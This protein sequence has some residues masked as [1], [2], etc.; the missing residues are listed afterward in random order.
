MK[1]YYSFK[2]ML[3]LFVCVVIVASFSSCGSPQTLY[4]WHKYENAAYK[5]SKLQTEKTNK[6]FDKQIKKVIAK[7]KGRRKTV[8]PGILA[9]YGFYL[10]KAGKPEE[11]STYFKKEIATYP[12]SEIFI[13]RIIKQI[14]Q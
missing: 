11:A 8:P 13:S 10:Y 6:E 5:N 12:E 14:E 7:Q 4:S 9:E 3:S 2:S 1:K